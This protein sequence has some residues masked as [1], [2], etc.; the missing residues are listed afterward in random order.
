MAKGIE[1]GVEQ[2][3]IK[4]EPFYAEVNGAIGLFK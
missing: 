2:F 3:R 4:A 1:Q